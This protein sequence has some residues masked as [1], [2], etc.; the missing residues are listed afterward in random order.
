MIPLGFC[1]VSSLRLWALIDIV[2]ILWMLISSYVVIY[3]IEVVDLDIATSA[4]VARRYDM[5]RSGLRGKRPMQASPVQTATPQIHH[6][7]SRLVTSCDILRQWNVLSC[8][9]V[10]AMV[11]C[12]QTH[13]TFVGRVPETV[14]LPD[15]AKTSLDII[16]TWGFTLSFTSS[17]GLGKWSPALHCRNLSQPAY[18]ETEWDWMNC[19]RFWWM[20][21]I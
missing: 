9:A 3:H 15:M 6:D 4:F 21:Q 20:K 19:D 11:P 7:T 16:L 8:R 1:C 12:F 5:S 18:L 13:E 17:S 10:S 14:R 2:D